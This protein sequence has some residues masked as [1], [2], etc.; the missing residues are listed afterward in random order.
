MKIGVLG[1]GMVGETIASKLVA[2]G[3]Q[4]M[5]GSREASNPK[6]AAWVARAG[7]G[8]RAG[9]FADAAEFGELLFNCTKGTVSLEALK[10]AGEP[11]LAGKVL[12]DVANILPVPAGGAPSLGEQIQR[13]FPSAKVVKTLNT[14]NCD[15]MVDAGKLPGPHSLFISGNDAAAKKQVRE[16]L[17]SFGWKDVL[18]L[19]DITTASASEAYVALWVTLYRTLGT[20]RFNVQLVR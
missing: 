12:I 3:H 9:T 15:L 1:T 2:L 10:M 7:A 16:L 19:G 4:V 6:S 11:R 20:A 13:A 5:I 18:D 14:V 8:A 17:S